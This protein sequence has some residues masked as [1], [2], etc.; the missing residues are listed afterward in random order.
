MVGGRADGILVGG[1]L[2]LVAATLGTPEQIDLSDRIFCFEDIQESPARIER[3]LSQLT[4]AGILQQAAGFVVGPLRWDVSDE[5]RSAYLSFETVL[6]HHLA[7]LGRPTLVGYPFGHVAHLVT[8]PLGTRV[9][10]DADARMLRVLEP[11]V[12]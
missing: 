8:M 1:T 2:S 3:Y 7:P 11:A 9:E 12:C 4:R 6:Q 10:L 5:E